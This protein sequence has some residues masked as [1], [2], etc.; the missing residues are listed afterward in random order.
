MNIANFLKAKFNSYYLKLLASFLFIVIF[1]LTVLGVIFNFYFVQAMEKEINRS[2]VNTLNQTQSSIDDL[3]M[4]VDLSSIQLSLNPFI[5]KYLTPWPEFDLIELSKIQTVFSNIRS[6]NENIQSLYLYYPGGNFIITSSGQFASDTFADMNWLNTAKEEKGKNVWMKTRE[7]IDIERKVPVNV[8]TYIRKLPLYKSANLGYIVTNIYEKSL[9]DRISNLDLGK[10]GSAFIV[11]DKGELITN[12]SK[13]LDDRKRAEF[14]KIKELISKGESRTIQKIDN[15]RVFLS[16]VT[17]NFN[18]W[19]YI[20]VQPLEEGIEKTRVVTKNILIAS[21]IVLIIAFIISY[22]FSRHMYFPISKLLNWSN[23]SGNNIKFKYKEFNLI[24]N[25]FNELILDNKV[26]N[27]KIRQAMP[28]IREKFIYDIIL[29]NVKD[30]NSIREMMDFLKIDWQKELNYAALTVEI[31][32]FEQFVHAYNQKEQNLYKFAI[33]NIT[34]EILK[35]GQVYNLTASTK[36]NEFAVILGLAGNEER[37]EKVF[38][39]SEEISRKIA[40][41]LP[42]T[43]TVGI[44]NFYGSLSEISLSYREAFDAAKYRIILGK[45]QIIFYNRIVKLGKSDYIYP[46]VQEEK[47]MSA[48][49]MGSLFQIKNALYDIFEDINRHPFIDSENVRQIFFNIVNSILRSIYEVG[50]DPKDITG[51]P[52]ELFMQ[53]NSLETLN[54]IQSWLEEVC[55]RIGQYISEKRECKNKI[56]VERMLEYIGLNFD[57]DISLETLSE[58][59]LYTPKYLNKILKSYTGKTFYELITDIRMEKAKKL[60][61][62]NG[63]QVSLIAEK[64]GYNNVQS[65]IRMFKKEAGIT[66]GQYR[67]DYNL[68]TK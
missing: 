7:I 29:G 16:V 8:V 31:D 40:E 34:G 14:L 50:F 19:K 17:S 26:L 48:L 45:N 56:I 24:N 32:N 59:I 47:L 64:V 39:L 4:Q 65:F 23:N 12:S 35:N 37:E 52:R 25:K 9:Y 10:N 46:L 42:V 61:L 15:N 36:P 41:F 38:K 51:N 22:L 49:K 28:T 30:E 67:L 43:V 44:G 2:N 55:I 33:C 57:K 6:T 53:L 66:P 54:E 21:I 20:M 1:S 5:S 62:E 11:N 60:L 27:D 18:G 3:L 63:L 68:K 58:N 13:K